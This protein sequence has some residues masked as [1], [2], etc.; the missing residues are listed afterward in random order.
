MKSFI[1]EVLRFDAPVHGILRF[2]K[3]DAEIAGA[4][5][6]KN[7]VVMPRYGAAN[8]DQTKFPNPDV[9]DIGRA[10]ASQHMSFGFGAH[11]CVGAA[12]A[13]QE[14]ISAFTALLDRVTDIAL[15][16]D[17]PQPAHEPSFFLRPL[18]QL[19]ITFRKA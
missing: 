14:M 2:T 4:K 6:L 3:G 8:R 18:K 19:P 1:E 11:Y 15:I 5:I 7:T 9:F 13:R 16:G 12:L 17:M 10:N